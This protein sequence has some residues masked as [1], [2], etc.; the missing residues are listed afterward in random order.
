LIVV[1]FLRPFD[2]PRF[3]TYAEFVDFFT[4]VCEVSE[5]YTSPNKR[6]RRTWPLLVQGLQFM[7]G[8]NIAHRYV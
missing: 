3:R 4:Q 2:E 6:H 1:P 8:Q 7:H 5:L